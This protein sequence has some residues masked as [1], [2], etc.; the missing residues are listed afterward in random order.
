MTKQGAIL[1]VEQLTY[2]LPKHIQHLNE[3]YY[4]HNYLN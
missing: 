4:D 3:D 2:T 1:N